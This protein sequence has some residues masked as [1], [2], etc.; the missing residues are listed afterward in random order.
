MAKLTQF[1][2]MKRRIKRELEAARAE[3]AMA[4][5]GAAS[6]LAAAHA[7]IEAIRSAVITAKMLAAWKK[8][9]SGELKDPPDLEFSVTPV[10]VK[11]PR[12]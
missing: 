5:L 10:M 7:Q 3:R 12:P 11:N 8:E 9:M 2:R 4:S 1:G 6:T